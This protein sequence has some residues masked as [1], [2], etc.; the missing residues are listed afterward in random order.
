MHSNL[1]INYKVKFSF[2]F[3]LRLFSNIFNNCKVIYLLV[4][5]FIFIY[6]MSLIQPTIFIDDNV[7]FVAPITKEELNEALVHMHPDKSPRPM[8]W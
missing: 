6:S 5:F 3:I 1:F 7:K 4:K 2:L 8:V